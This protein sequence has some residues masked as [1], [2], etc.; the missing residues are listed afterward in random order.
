MS[1]SVSVPFGP[2]RGPTCGGRSASDRETPL[3]TVVN[4]PAR[5]SA[6]GTDPRHT[7]A[8]DRNPRGEHRN[9]I[10]GKPTR[11]PGRAASEHWKR[12]GSTSYLSRGGVLR[13]MS[14]AAALPMYRC[15]G[16]IC[17]VTLLL[18]TKERFALELGEQREGLRRVD[19]WAA[20]QW[21][22][23]DDDMAYVPQLL[24]SVQHDCE[25]LDLIEVSPPLFPGLSPA[26]V[27]HAAATRRR[28]RATGTMAVP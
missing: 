8:T 17:R 6:T 10:E 16:T 14:L 18:G 25:R 23:C 22:T 2:I 26:A 27:L 1:A 13:Q 4:G 19:T 21:L 11:S 7:Q 5:G 28:G 15:A 12:R 3:I 9:I 24:L 20:G